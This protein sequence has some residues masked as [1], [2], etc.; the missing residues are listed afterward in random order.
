MTAAQV[1]R[2]SL[3]GRCFPPSFEPSRLG[4]RLLDEYASEAIQPPPRKARPD[5]DPAQRQARDALLALRCQVGE[6]EAFRELVAEMHAPLLYFAGKLVADPDRALDVLQEVWLRVFRT[7]KQLREPQSLRQ[8]LY[9]TTRGLA[10]DHVRA[11]S[12]RTRHE[13]TF[14]EQIADQLP[15]PAADIDFAPKAADAATLHRA[16]DALEIHHREVLVLHFL[17]DMS[18]A[19]I[20]AVLDCPAGTVKSR[21]HYAKQAAK[22]ILCRGER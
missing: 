1:Q 10:I 13:R 19:E 21:L 16:L 20:A 6:P 9:R 15:E 2:R 22:K 3:D 7:I 12:A 18:V 8:W 11:H 14:A 4:L 17:E 5:M